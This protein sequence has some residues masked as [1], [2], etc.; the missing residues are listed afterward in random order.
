MCTV[1]TVQLQAGVKNKS[2]YFNNTM[3]FYDVMTCQ[4]YGEMNLN[5]YDK[6]LF[7][8]AASVL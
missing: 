5:E 2:Y 6:Q 4:N 8:E 3:V 1:Y 7:R